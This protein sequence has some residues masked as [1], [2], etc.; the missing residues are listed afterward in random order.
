MFRK[1]IICRED[2]T[3]YLIR[4]YLFKSKLFQI[5][6][7][8]VLQ[9]DPDCL[10]DHPWNFISLILWG[11]YWEGTTPEQK[12]RGFELEFFKIKHN[13]NI[14]Y[15]WYGPL[16][17]LFRKAEWKHRLKLH[18]DNKKPIRSVDNL[19]NICVTGFKPKPCTT[20]VIMF[21]RKREWGFFTKAGWVPWQKYNNKEQRCD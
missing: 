21:K 18:D 4:T 2:G 19:G 12:L 13:A 3:P 14:Y 17:L 16:S 11:G 5:V 6:I 15:R 10:H 9:S 8:K 20:L 1:K 7:H